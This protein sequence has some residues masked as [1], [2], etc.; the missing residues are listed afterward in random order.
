LGWGEARGDRMDKQKGRGLEYFYVC[1]LEKGKLSL[2][3]G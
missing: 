3:I 1:K 2:L